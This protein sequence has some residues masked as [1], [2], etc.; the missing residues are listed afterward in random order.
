MN[1]LQLVNDFLMESGLGDAIS[2]VAGQE[3]EE[4]LAV[5]W[6]ADAWVEI[7]RVRNWDFRWVEGSV[8]LTV[9]KS[10]YTLTELGLQEGDEIDYSSFLLS[11]SS[12]PEAPY[13]RLEEIPYQAQ[14]TRVIQSGRPTQVCKY[15]DDSIRFNASPDDTYEL[16][17]EYYLAPVT[18]STDLDVPSLPSQY[19]K[20]IVWKALEQY[21]REQGN[22]WKALYEVAV[23]NY[24]AL[25]STLLNRETG[26]VSF[27]PSPFLYSY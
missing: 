13:Q 12:D 10:R 9:N 26:K 6:I 11:T 4:A 20:I 7:Q 19:H 18:L 21:A 16:K 14:M 15:P 22:E 24:N 8:A 25:F 1:Y 5:K 2:S 3:D 23:R 17:Y 27:A